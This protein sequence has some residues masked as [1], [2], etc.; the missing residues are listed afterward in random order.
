M[1]DEDGIVVDGMFELNEDGTVKRG[2]NGSVTMSKGTFL[3]RTVYQSDGSREEWCIGANG[4]AK[5]GVTS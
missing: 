1:T 5:L 3:L 4:S 2:A